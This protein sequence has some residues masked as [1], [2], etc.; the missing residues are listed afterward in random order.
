M[1]AKSM[2]G[3]RIELLPLGQIKEAKQ[4]SKDHDIGE[5][6]VSVGRFGFVRRAASG[7]M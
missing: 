3:Q 1:G 4:N 5:L 6:S 2:D 7:T